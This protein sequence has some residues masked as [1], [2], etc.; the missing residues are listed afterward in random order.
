MSH[1]EEIKE[2]DALVSL[3][4]EPNVDMFNEIREKVLSYGRLAIP[5]LEEAWVNT[6]GDHDSI[7]IE[8]VIEEIKQEELIQEFNNWAK[9]SDSNIIK[10]YVILSKY[11]QSDFDEGLY[12][13]KFE[14]LVRETW[15]E[16]NDSL[17]ALEKI[18]VVNHVFYSVYQHIAEADSILKPE[19]YYLNKVLDY[20]KGNPV[21]LGV[22]YIAIAQ[23][24]DIPVFGVNLPGHF[25]LGYMDD[26]STM[27]FPDEYIEED[28]L[29][30]LNAG[31]NGAI[32]TGN[33]IDHYINKIKINH[34]PEFYLPLS[35]LNVIVRMINELIVVLEKENNNSK[36]NGLKSLLKRL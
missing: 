6:L 26:S 20:K 33:E 14:K 34:K 28:V 11:L 2:L 7:R 24:L 8:N 4:D 32:F 29:F 19:T 5:V 13:S 12:I 1:V 23:N 22:L 27:K 15:L 10:G 31:K 30:Y 25:I 21:S 16:I 9:E 35:N 18:K 17:T 36:I 3:L